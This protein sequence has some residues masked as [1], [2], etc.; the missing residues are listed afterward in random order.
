MTAAPTAGGA[1]TSGVGVVGVG[2][3][4]LGMFGPTRAAH[5]GWLLP[6]SGIHIEL[7]RLGGFFM[8]LTGAVA[9]PVG[10]YLIGYARRE[11]LGRVAVAVVPL[12][13]AAML[14]VPAAGSVTTFLLA[15]ELMAIASLILVLSEHTRP[16]VRAAGLWYAVMTQLGFIALLVGLVVLAAAGG[17]DRFAGLGA[18]SDG[19]R[20]VV[21]VLTLAGFGSKAGL[22]P[23]HAWLPRAHPE[24][25]SPVSALM[26][27]AMVNLGCYGIARI[28]LQLLGPGPRWWGLALLAVGG[29]SALYGVLQ[30]SV[31]TD[32]KRLLAYSTTENMGLITLALG[33]A[34]LFADAGAYGPASI[35]VA[36]AM[37]HLIAHA[38]FKS[39]A[40][41]AAGS[42]LAATGLR[43]LDLLGGLARRMPATT[44]FFGVAALG[45][46]GLPLGA[47]FV[48]EWLLVQ[49]L[50]HAAPG[51]DPV[52]ALTTPLAVGVVA[53]ATG[54]S[55]AAMTKAFGIGFLAR[56]RSLHAEAAR[57]APV[58]MRAGMAMVAAACLALAVAP[59]LVAPAVRGAAATLPAARSVEFTDLGA[60]VRLP[61]MSGSIAPGVIAGG[62]LAAALVVAV[63][64]RWRCRRRPAS[65]ILPLWACGA[66]ELTARMQYTATAFA[67]PLQRVFDDVLRPDTDVEV[68]HTAESR[69]MAE[70]ITYRTAI[71]DAIERRL[72]PPVVGA[73]AAA[74]GLLRRAHPGSVHLYLAYGALG[75]LIVLVVAR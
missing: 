32:L 3:G 16:Q 5:I 63:L 65:A 27:A 8:A 75:V 6:L 29:T 55:V 39:L 54:L 58:S 10:C 33:A 25:P 19:V 21:F 59:L 71:T 70:R 31:A 52:V 15:W 9:V 42:V 7:D 60:V 68:T 45:A 43:D 73:V 51:H 50:V 12:F 38:A 13:V 61:G 30:A 14:L 69:Y 11:H 28:D 23:L 48:G 24:A 56:P 74:A 66:A 57:E 67:E 26:S 34:T 1:V 41:L 72:Y 35:A 36:A 18:V 20:T 40:F 22:V 47:G 4:L 2:V 37:L 44:A 46:C 64:A 62:V 17:S 53:L 49:S